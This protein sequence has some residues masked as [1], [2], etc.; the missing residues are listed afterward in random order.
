MLTTLDPKDVSKFLQEQVFALYQQQDDGKYHPTFKATA[1]YA[2]VREV[3][4]ETVEQASRSQ[5]RS[6][7]LLNELADQLVPWCID[8][9]EHLSTQPGTTDEESE[10]SDNESLPREPRSEGLP[11][12]TEVRGTEQWKLWSSLE[13]ERVAD[14][15]AR[16][17]Q[18]SGSVKDLLQ[19]FNS[20]GPSSQEE[21]ISGTFTTPPP[22]SS[23]PPGPSRAELALAQTLIRDVS[24]RP[25]AR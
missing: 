4:Q 1:G 10:G 24:P 18:D 12:T 7:R 20:L 17:N 9:E 16:T 15:Y 19:W 11:I 3:C 5:G 2:T 14:A 8:G 6:Y 23:S 25:R 13:Q 22:P 21:V